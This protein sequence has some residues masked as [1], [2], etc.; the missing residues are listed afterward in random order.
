MAKSRACFCPRLLF[1]PTNWL[2]WSWLY[3]ILW[4]FIYFKYFSMLLQR[5][6]LVPRANQEPN[7]KVLK[8]HSAAGGKKALDKRKCTQRGN[9]LDTI[10]FPCLARLL[11]PESSF[12]LFLEICQSF[13]I[14]SL[15]WKQYSEQH[16]YWDVHWV[17]FSPKHSPTLPSS[18]SHYIHLLAH[19]VQ[20]TNSLLCASSLLSP[21]PLT[22]RSL[23]P[24]HTDFQAISQASLS[25]LTRKQMESK[26]RNCA[27]TNI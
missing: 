19:G 20:G 3:T 18:L 14:F 11:V 21:H 2:S 5:P 25:S 24:T 6:A 17:H 16:T 12:L 9:A 23:S 27:E 13:H 10:V 4:F 15:Y 22:F 1:S 8:W 7:H 26:E